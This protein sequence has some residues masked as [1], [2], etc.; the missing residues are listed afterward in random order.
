[1]S[2][3]H[4]STRVWVAGLAA[5]VSLW[6]AQEPVARVLA[7]WAPGARLWANPELQRLLGETRWQSCMRPI[8]A[9]LRWISWQMVR[10]EVCTGIATD[11]AKNLNVGWLP[12]ALVQADAVE[13]SE[14]RILY[15]D[16]TL[17]HTRCGA[18]IVEPY[19]YAESTRKIWGLMKVHLQQPARQVA[20]ELTTRIVHPTIENDDLSAPMEEGRRQFQASINGL[21]PNAIAA[22]LPIAIGPHTGDFATDSDVDNAVRKGLDELES[23]WCTARPGDCIRGE[24]NPP[25]CH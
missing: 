8:D 18:L 2:M 22:A 4:G 6:L 11:Y 9:R 5:V 10:A 1:M 19:N 12:L 24:V 14:G 15:A 16:R 21:S 17:G 13:T 20:A 7:N 3:S 23:R 25:S